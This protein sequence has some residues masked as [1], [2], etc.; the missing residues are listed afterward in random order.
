[1]VNVGIIGATGYTG[2]EAIKILLRHGQA[3]LTA[4]T[5]L[6]EEC[7]PI[8]DIFPSLRKRI[9]LKVEPL[10]LDRFVKKVDVALCC[11]PHKVSMSL[12][13]KMLSAGLKVID[14]SADYR[15]RDLATYEKYYCKHTDVENL[16]K[17]AFGLP[18]LFRSKIVGKQLVANPGC[19]PTGSSL[20]LAPLLA[21]GLIELDTIISN[22]VTGVSGAGRKA[23]LA[24]H[25][26]EMNENMFPYAPGGVHRH[27]PEINQI[28]GDVAGK[29]V[30]VLFQPHVGPFDRGILSS[31]YARPTKPLTKEKLGELYSKFY[32]SEI[33]VR[34]LNS[35]PTIK[36]IARSN[37][38]DIFPTIS[39]DG[40]AV[41]IFSAIDNL[42]KGA[43]GQAIQNLNIICGL[44]ESEGLL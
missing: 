17:A 27:S 38:C 8:G 7:G 4:L 25:L 30:K 29:P 9:D 44:P 14:F 20:A 23:T 5:A 13:P 43:S 34:I 18:E 6:P 24:Y 37:F 10:E 2:E 33:F 40:R 41:I 39:V 15:L 3:K 31:V 12:I 11:L 21:E 1:M 35:P 19:Y 42:I 32:G 16:A 22:A 26:P 28:C 36:A